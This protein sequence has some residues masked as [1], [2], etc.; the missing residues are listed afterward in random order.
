VLSIG[1]SADKRE[2][3]TVPAGDCKSVR[4][5]LTPGLGTVVASTPAPKVTPKPKPTP[6]PK[7]KSTSTP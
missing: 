4:F 5:V 3:V 2:I 1:G 6:N 7:P